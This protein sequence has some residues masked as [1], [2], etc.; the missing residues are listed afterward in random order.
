MAARLDGF[1]LAKDP[2]LSQEMRE[3]TQL[4][5][6][7]VVVIKDERPHFLIGN[8]F[9]GK[10]RRR[11]IA[12]HIAP[13]RKGF[14][15]GFHVTCFFCGHVEVVLLADF[16]PQRKGLFP[17]GLCPGTATAYASRFAIAK[18]IAREPSANQPT[19]L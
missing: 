13:L 8:L 5:I 19:A 2:R 3:I 10:V 11:L 17:S 15:L 18:L 12:R 1:R 9:L 6:V 7:L 14:R 16:P 4:A